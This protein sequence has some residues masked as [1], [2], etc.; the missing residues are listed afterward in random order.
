VTD[1]IVIGGG[2]AGL[3][4]AIAASAR[5]LRCLVSEQRTPPIHKACGEGLMPDGLRALRALGVELTP[6]HGH[7]FAGIRFISGR[8][9]VDAAFP[10][11]HG[12]GVRRTVLHRLLVERAASVGVDLRWGTAATLLDLHTVRLGPDTVTARWVIGADGPLS[13]VRRLAALEGA[14]R[15]RHRYAVRR[16]YRIRPWSE[17]VEV[18]WGPRGQFYVTPVGAEEICL[19]FVARAPGIDMDAALADSAGLAARLGSAPRASRPLGGLSLTS[20]LRRVV[21]DPVALVGDA[22]GSVDAVTGEGLSLAFRQA[23]VLADA[24]ERE[25]LP[26]YERSHPRLARRAH[27]MARLMLTMDRW[28][29]FG[30]LAVA[31]LA[32]TP[33]LFARLLAVHVGAHPRLLVSSL[34]AAALLGGGAPG[35]AEPLAVTLDPE[36][37]S[38]RWVLRGFPDTVH[39]SFRL[40]SGALWL[41]PDSGAADGCLRIDAR[42]G[43]SGNASRDRKM[44]GEIL[45]SARFP[46]V[47]L[48]P[49]RVE[50]ALPVAGDGTMR[51]HGVLSLH[52]G[53]HPVILA[54]RLTRRGEGIDAATTLSIPFVAWGV[55]DPSFLVFRT[56]KTV[57]LD[58]HTAGAVTPA[59]VPRPAACGT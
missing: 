7:A 46:A 31:A 6:A 39:G 54:V 43:E 19:V 25:R 26:D 52:G 57:E 45:E 53:T 47:T 33:A 37:T 30:R 41:D 28:P 20:I 16:H 21:R 14:R 24:L 18:H 55:T 27:A 38:V 12:I 40:E 23:R 29:R 17:F 36:R 32:R 35:A 48:R 13:R 9:A 5:G 1:V 34:L 11:G 56:S 58:I 44:H 22:S 15:R 42:S 59:P 8:H 3:A 50:G 49:T 2:P 51:V 4:V 10:N